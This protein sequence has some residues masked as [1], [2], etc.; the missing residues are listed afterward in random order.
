MIKITTHHTVTRTRRRQRN[1]DVL[2]LV[3][4]SLQ[5]QVGRLLIEAV[6]T[7]VT[8]ENGATE[9]VPKSHIWDDV[10]KPDESEVTYGEMDPGDALFCLGNT[11]H[12]AG[13]NTTSDFFRSVVVTLF[14]KGKEALQ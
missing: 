3:S 8:R 13:G 7:K 1:W 11:Y 10:R 5:D 14:C 9:V 2:S 4:F 12:G 6:V